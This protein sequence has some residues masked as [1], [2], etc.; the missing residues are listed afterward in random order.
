I[1]RER[2]TE[3]KLW[4]TLANSLTTVGRLDEAVAALVRATKQAP[5]SG[6][7][8]WHLSNLKSY[9]FS[10]AEIA[11]MKQALMQASSDD[12][13]LHIHFALGKAFEDA[14]A[15]EESFRHYAA[16]NAI[17]ASRFGE[18]QTITAQIDQSVALLTPEF[19]ERNKGAGCNEAG[20]IFVVGVHRSGSTLI[21]QILASHSM[22]EGIAELPVIANV[23]GRLER[24]MRM[25]APRAIASLPP[26]AFSE[27]GEEILEAFRPF[28][29]TERPYFVDKKPG[30]WVC[31]GLV[32]VA[33]PNARII[34]ARRHPMACGFSN[35][36][37]HYPKGVGF[38]SRLR[39]IGT[40][41]Q[42][43]WRFMNHF[44][45]VQPGV[46]HRVVNEH[47]VSDPEHE[48][49]T[50]LGYLGLPFEASCLEFHRNQ[51]AVRT[52]SAE[53]VRQPI[54]SKGVEQWKNYEPWLGELKEALGPALHHWND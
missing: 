39:T 27:I 46:V 54:N 28:R 7:P 43:Y 44:D 35:F 49:R 38:A 29:R 3:P 12:D 51:R 6:E 25:P 11:L 37:Q 1:V 42:D 53:Q 8:W 10:P 31:L 26:S 40:F 50:M 9:K 17:G 18:N 48:I 34:D 14:R 24:E 13:R 30:N 22:I 36:K 16:A 41:Y 47:L 4:C 32:R 33:L 23:C 20:P 2:P 21:E 52:P 5:K 19:F 15:F 45:R